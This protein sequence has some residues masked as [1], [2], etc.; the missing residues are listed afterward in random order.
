MKI[1]DHLTLA[2]L[3]H[4]LQ[5][6]EE[7]LGISSHLQLLNWLQQGVRPFI[8]HDIVIAAWGDFSLGLVSYDLVSA[9]PGLRTDDLDEGV[10]HPLVLDFFARWQHSNLT[11]YTAVSSHGFN[12]HYHSHQELIERL[13]VMPSALVHGIKDQRGRHDCLYIFLGPS[14]LGLDRPR[15]L[16]RYL[17]PYVDAA[18]RQVAHLPE[19]Y[20]PPVGTETVAPPE[21]TPATTDIDDAST[22]KFGLSAREHGIMEWVRAGKTN[23]E[24]GMILD[25]S[26]FTVKNHIQRIF[27]KLNVVN[28]AQAVSKMGAVKSNGK[29]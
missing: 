21:A 18:F 3:H 11:P 9:L 7:S 19:Q 28:R 1:P 10:L 27:K 15:G 14:E 20:L 8:P 23:L 2:E 22:D 24:I 6:V 5:A 13:R 17:L 4:L 26:A 16:L 29:R 12:A 25:I